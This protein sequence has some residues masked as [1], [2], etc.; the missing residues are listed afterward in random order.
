MTTTRITASWLYAACLGAMI[1]AVVGGCASTDKSAALLPAPRTIVADIPAPTTF[2]LEE[3]RS[4]TF[5]NGAFRYIDLL[6]EGSGSKEAV[7]EFYK[8]QMPISRWD[9]L[10][11][12]VSQGQTIIEYAKGNERCRITISGGG[13]FRSTYVHITAWPINKTNQTKTKVSAKN[14]G[15]F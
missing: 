8:N 13:T 2:D 14:K 10:T 7:G 6:Y 3:L 11:K 15:N 9:P 5:D 1:S 12:H 4:R